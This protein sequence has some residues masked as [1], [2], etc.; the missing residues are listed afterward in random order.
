[1]KY[2]GLEIKLTP[3]AEEVATFYAALL[4]T[5]YVKNDTF[6][7]NFF[8]DWQVILEESEENPLIEDFEKY[9][10][11]RVDEFYG[12]RYLDGCKEK[13]GR[14]DHPKTG[15]LKSRVTLKQITNNI[16]KDA[17]ILPP[18][19]G[20]SWGGIL[21]DNTVTWLT[22]WKENVNDSRKYVFLAANS[23]LKARELDKHIE[24]ICCDLKYRLSSVCQ[25]ATAMYLIDRLAL[26][27]GNEKTAKD[28]V[29]YVNSAEVIKQVFKNLK[30]F[31]KDKGPTEPL[32]DRL[33][34]IN[35]K[36]RELKN[37]W[38]SGKVN[39]KKGQINE[40]L[41]SQIEKLAECI[42]TTKL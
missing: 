22:T 11:T 6:N 31:I 24:K 40:K 27:A 25:C 34:N 17:L 3:E 23:S 18:P 41:R 42:K 16:S 28:S 37:E 7:K 32:F 9:E 8:K 15:S 26:R 10:K 1:M 2:N 33:M 13:V 38:K 35:E 39:P 30:I 21:L 5:D 14:G 20:H 4:N 29:R 19:A 36:E 12:Y